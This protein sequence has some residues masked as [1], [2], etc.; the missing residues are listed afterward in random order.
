MEG[1]FGPPSFSATDNQ[2]VTKMSKI[3]QVLLRNNYNTKFGRFKAS[4]MGVPTPIPEGVINRLGLP[5]SAVI[6]DDTYI[7]PQSRPQEF[8]DIANLQDH[9]R[10][11][12][13][14]NKRVEAQMAKLAAKRAEQTAATAAAAEQALG[15]SEGVEPEAPEV[16][17]DNI[18]DKSVREI[19]TYVANSESFDE[20]TQLMAAEHAGKTRQSVVKAI[21]AALAEF[22]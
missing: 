16:P 4:K 7:P 6:V 1:G 8:D 9:E 10:M 21:E 22:E 11:E 14:V 18:L 12:A 19:K 2:R 20:L 15:A 5:K 17:E 3:V 13:E